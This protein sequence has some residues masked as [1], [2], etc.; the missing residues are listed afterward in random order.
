MFSDS[1]SPPCGIYC[2]KGVFTLYNCYIV[3][4]S[5]T[6]AQKY[7]RIIAHAGYNANIAR[8][9]PSVSGTGCGYAVSVHP[10]ELSEIAAVLR[11]E[12]YY[13]LR[14]FFENMPGIFE[15]KYI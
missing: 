1:V 9:S 11:E 14:A 2:R 6:V 7:V 13:D 10:R 12:G 8:L 15:E 4:R 5:I 3:C